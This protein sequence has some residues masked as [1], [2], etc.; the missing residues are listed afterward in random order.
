MKKMI[1][2]TLAALALSSCRPD[3][4]APSVRYCHLT[5]CEVAQ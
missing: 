2:L 3:V 4:P 5:G 1:L